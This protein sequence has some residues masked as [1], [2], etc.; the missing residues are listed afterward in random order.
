[1]TRNTWQSSFMMLQA[2]F[3]EIPQWSAPE[4]FV[5][6]CVASNCC[7]SILFLT[8]TAFE[9][10]CDVPLHVLECYYLFVL[11]VACM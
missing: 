1:M 6:C 5:V 2:N 11:A 3:S 8:V 7:L 4:D 10:C 9:L